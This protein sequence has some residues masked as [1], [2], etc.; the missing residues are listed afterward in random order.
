MPV[1]WNWQAFMGSEACLKWARRD[2]ES[3]EAAMLITQGRTACVQAGGNLGIFPKFLARHFATV[4]TFEPEPELFAALCFNARERNIVKLQAAVGFERT[5]VRMECSRRDNSGR[6]VHEGLTHVAGPGTL[7]T[8]RIDD[9]ALPV[10]DLIYL[11]IEGWE[12]YA[13]LGANDTIARCRPV[14]GIEINRNIGFTGASAESLRT[15]VRSYG[16]THRL[17]MHSD[18]IYAPS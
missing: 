18:E 4:Y 8:L 12:H 3:L 13:L 16:Y 5:P 1:N 9:L 6:A 14:I 10:C 2:L 11:D 15:L 17:T 7:P